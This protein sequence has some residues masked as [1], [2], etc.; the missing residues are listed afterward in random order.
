MVVE[1]EG[2]GVGVAIT[3]SVVEVVLVVPQEEGRGFR[4]ETLLVYTQHP[5]NPPPFQTH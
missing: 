4:E 3:F 5:I 2:S 1:E